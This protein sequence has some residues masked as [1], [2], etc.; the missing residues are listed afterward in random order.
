MAFFTR[1]DYSRQLRQSGDTTGIF[2]GSSTFEQNVTIGSGLTVGNGITGCGDFM[3][4]KCKAEGPWEEMQGGCCYTACSTGYT[5]M[6]A[7]YSA[8]SASCMVTITPFSAITGYSAVLAIGQAPIPPL[9]GTNSALSINPGI[10]ASTVQI[11]KLGLVDA[12]LVG[13]VVDLQIDEN[14]NVVKGAS[15]SLR[16]KHHLRPINKN[17]YD[18]LLDLKSYFFKYRAT[19]M[20]GF[21]LIAEELHDLGFTELVLYDGKGRPDNI[22][23]KLLG[24]ALLNLIQN[25]YKDGVNLYYEPTSETDT[26]TKVIK[27]DYISDGEHLLV[28]TKECKIT[29]NSNKDKKIKIKSLSNIEIFPDIGLIDSKWESLKLDGDSCVEFAFVEELDCWVIV[30]SDGLKQS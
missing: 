24:V 14:G 4:Y 9:S 17:R 10:S 7:P 30:G 28:V 2:S 16:Y 26:K 22:D 1:V 18:T 25:L 12:G 20:D 29:L 6:V 5:F 19:G 23:Y 21:G 3:V 15:S 8:T 27:E 13:G 11:A